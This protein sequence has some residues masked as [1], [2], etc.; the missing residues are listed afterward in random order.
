M[1]N[2]VLHH[3]PT[4]PRTRF[5]CRRCFPS[6]DGTK[7]EVI[8]SPLA[9]RGAPTASIPSGSEESCRTDPPSRSGGPGGR[10]CRCR[11]PPWPTRGGSSR[12]RPPPPASSSSPRRTDGNGGMSI[13]AQLVQPSGRG[14]LSACAGSGLGWRGRE[15]A[16][17]QA[18]A[19]SC[20]RPLPRDL[21]SSLATP[22]LCPESRVPSAVHNPARALAAC[23]ARG[24]LGFL[25]IQAAEL[26]G[27]RGAG[28]R[29]SEFEIE[30]CMMGASGVRVLP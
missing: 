16:K 20:R 4:H 27:R 1:A 18:S 26:V 19:S 29:S 28:P 17:Q 5:T 12:R 13:D 30:R 11:G 2:S 3:Q 9:T 21:A 14:V 25:R 24:G 8:S 22:Q 15:E 23:G 7:S 6:S 10:C